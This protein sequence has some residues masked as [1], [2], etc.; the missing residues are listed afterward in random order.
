MIARGSKVVDHF[1]LLIAVHDV[2]ELKL[3]GH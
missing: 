2:E 1:H 3:W